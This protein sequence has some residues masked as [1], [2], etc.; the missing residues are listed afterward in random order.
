MIER[1]MT[2]EVSEDAK[3]ELIKRGFDPALGARPLRRAMQQDVEDQLSE[4]IL[5][6]ELDEG[7][8]VTVDFDGTE[9]TFETRQR[10]TV[11]AGAG[12]APASE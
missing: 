4:R 1:D 11:G 10:E 12:N 3:K 6:G 5:R 9:F 8:Q 2:I 7:D